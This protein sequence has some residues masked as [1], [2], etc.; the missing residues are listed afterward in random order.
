M[1]GVTLL[2]E[3]WNNIVF[4]LILLYHLIYGLRT[5][6]SLTATYYPNLTDKKRGSA[7]YKDDP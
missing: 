4:I 3:D 7:G 2:A 5:G 1:F 6:K